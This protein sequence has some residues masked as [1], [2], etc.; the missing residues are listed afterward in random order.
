MDLVG[1]DS[2]CG[3]G[4]PPPLEPPAS[5]LCVSDGILMSLALRWTL[6]VD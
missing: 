2:F 4:L 1:L 3:S 6:K 5:Q